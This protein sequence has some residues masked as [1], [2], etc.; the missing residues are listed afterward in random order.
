MINAVKKL[1]THDA[2]PEAIDT[3]TK[4]FRHI[5]QD[6]MET[7]RHEIINI[8]D[9][10]TQEKQADAIANINKN[11]I[12]ISIRPY[13]EATGG[14]LAKGEVGAIA[15]NSGRGKTLHMVNLANAYTL[16]GYNVMYV[17]LEELSARMFYRF[18]KTSLGLLTKEFPALA[19][20]P[21]L[22][23]LQGAA[24]TFRKGN[25]KKLQKGFED[26]KGVKI[27]DL[28]FTRY[29]P[30]ELSIDGLEQLVMDEVVPNGRKA[31]RRA[32]FRR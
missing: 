16:A 29:G 21:E 5:T 18:Y 9:P 14:G 6:A 26:S 20:H 32:V 8:N 11:L 12:P 3:F 27:G 31:P 19:N 15:A 7:G 1:A 30:H 13:Q 17:A 28:W 22:L 10:A 23:S 25:M 4:D 24:S 2:T